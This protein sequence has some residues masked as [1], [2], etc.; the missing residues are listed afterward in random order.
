MNKLALLALF[1]L[2]ATA[3]TSAF[4]ATATTTATPTANPLRDQLKAKQD[5]VEKAKAERAAKKVETK[6]EI[7]KRKIQIAT[8]RKTRADAWRKRHAESLAAKKALKKTA[9]TATPAAAPVAT[10]VAAAPAA[11]VTATATATTEK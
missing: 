9:T 6:E 11:A 4:A 10:P 5:D 1:A 3:S 2:A 8:D 7:E